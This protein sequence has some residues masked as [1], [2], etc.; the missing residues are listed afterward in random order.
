MLDQ[1]GEELAFTAP[2]QNSGVQTITRLVKELE[3]L[4]GQGLQPS[5]TAGVGLARAWLDQTREGTGNF[6]EETIRNFNEWHEWMTSV[7]WA[8]E[9]GTAMP[10]WP[11]GWDRDHEAATGATEE[12]RE[13]AGVPSVKRPGYP[14][15]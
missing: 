10:A 4:A 14:R 12:R 13:L 8:C 5:L 15:P 2:N 3:E 9:G 7:L 1:L 6:S 11:E